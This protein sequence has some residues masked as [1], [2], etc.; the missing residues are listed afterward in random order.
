MQKATAPM[1]LRIVTWNVNSLRSVL[2]KGFLDWMATA[3][4]DVLC[5]QEVRAEIKHLYPLEQLFP[6]YRAFWH[7]AVRSGYAGVA[8][9]S[10]FEPVA[11]ERGLKGNDDPE[12]RALTLDFGTFRVGSYYAPNATPNTPKI[13]IKI[14]WL[15][16]FQ[17]H[18]AAAPDVPLILAGDFNVAHTSRDSGGIAHPPYMNGCTP[19]E[20]ET[21]QKIF[22]EQ[23]FSDPLREQEGTKLLNTWWAPHSFD[24]H[25]SD[26]MRYDYLLLQKKFAHLV[27]EQS[28][29]TSV[30]GSDHCPV[31]MVIDLSTHHLPPARTTGQD[32][33]L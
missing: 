9:L 19:E 23:T 4:P 1:P 16:Q 14:A 31:R 10:R 18:I 7:P 15:T 5:L 2:Q 27:Q 32:Y 11:I 28:I 3:Q 24:R 22:T 13:P 26:G 29:E 6:G 8:M 30:R 20:R 25:M 17:K 12:G 33:L 21:F